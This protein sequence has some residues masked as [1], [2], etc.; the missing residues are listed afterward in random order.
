MHPFLLA[1]NCCY[2]T[3]ATIRRKYTEKQFNIPFIL[4]KRAFQHTKERQHQFPVVKREAYSLFFLKAQGYYSSSHP[5]QF[6]SGEIILSKQK[7]Y[8][9]MSSIW[10]TI[11][12][13]S[14]AFSKVGRDCKK[15]I[16]SLK[17]VLARDVVSCGFNCC[18]YALFTMINRDLK[19]S[20]RFFA[21]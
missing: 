11:C 16:R 19:Q 3:I 15:Y 9:L 4:C 10:F 20:D 1:H 13:F 5:A 2:V 8:S 7:Y 6:R 12:P 17:K 21:L 18:Y 14:K